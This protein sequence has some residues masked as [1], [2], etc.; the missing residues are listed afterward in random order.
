ML[1]CVCVLC[2]CMCVYVCVCVESK[3]MIYYENYVNKLSI[4]KIMLYTMLSFV[5]KTTGN[6]DDNLVKVQSNQ[7]LHRNIG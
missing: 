4:V 3:Y 6:P 7:N 5:S 2:V 1:V